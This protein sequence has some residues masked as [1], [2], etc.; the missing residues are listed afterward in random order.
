M[1][2]NTFSFQ[3][4]TPHN[5]SHEYISWAL[6]FYQFWYLSW[7]YTTKHVFPSFYINILVNSYIYFALIPVVYIWSYWNCLIAFIHNIYQTNIKYRFVVNINVIF[8][9]T[10]FYL[11]S[12][13]GKAR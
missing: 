3:F 11:I 13:A 6:S 1:E 9:I 2:L 10:W 4:S 8:R 7:N 12:T 5:K